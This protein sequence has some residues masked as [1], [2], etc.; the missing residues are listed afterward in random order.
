MVFKWW[1]VVR[2]I[3]V[4]KCFS[5]LVCLVF[6]LSMSTIIAEGNISGIF[7]S[8]IEDFDEFDLDYFDEFLDE[9]G[10]IVDGYAEICNDKGG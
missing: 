4:K 10:I 3:H 6:L 2:N 9:V 5:I 8:P 7:S 1:I